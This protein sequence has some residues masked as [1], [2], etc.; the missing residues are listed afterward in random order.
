MSMSHIKTKLKT[1][2]VSLKIFELRKLSLLQWVSILLSMLLE[3]KAQSQYKQNVGKHIT[4]ASVLTQ[5]S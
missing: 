3:K 4:G 2:T 1:V 5:E